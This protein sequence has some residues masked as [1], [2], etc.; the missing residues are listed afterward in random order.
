MLEVSEAAI[1]G[2]TGLAGPVVA[3]L[4]E[5]GVQLHLDDFGTGEASLRHLHGLMLQGLKIDRSLVSRISAGAGDLALLRSVLALAGV[6]GLTVTAEGVETAEQCSLLRALGCQQG[7][8]F[9]FGAAAEPQASERLVASGRWP[10]P[11]E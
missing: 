7:Q 9:L 2:G 4:R 10:A 5:L 8:G 1:N 3:R 6:L 11:P